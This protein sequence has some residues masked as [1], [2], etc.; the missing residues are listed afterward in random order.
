MDVERPS[1]SAVDDLVDLWVALAADQRAVGSH[2]YA[3]RNRDRIREALAGRVTVGG[4]FVARDEDRRLVGFVTFYP[5]SETYAQDRTRGIVENLYVVPERR[6]EG[7]GTRLLHAAED[8]LAAGGADAVALE[9]L[10]ANDRAR[11]FYAQHGYT[12]HRIEFERAVAADDET[13]T[14]HG[15]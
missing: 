5:E 11:R 4:A 3:E 6:G 7:V 8:A 1:V 9:A 2:L 10:A 14:N 13:D 15:E 12:P